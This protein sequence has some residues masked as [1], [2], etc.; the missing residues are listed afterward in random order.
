[1][2]IILSNCYPPKLPDGLDLEI[3]T[4][5]SLISAYKCCNDPKKREHVTPWI[6]DSGNNFKIGSIKY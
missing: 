5:E 2:L 4:R 6:R 3:F 1:M